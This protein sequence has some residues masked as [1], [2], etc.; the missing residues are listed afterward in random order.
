M[1]LVLVCFPHLSSLVSELLMVSMVLTIFWRLFWR[2]FDKLFKDLFDDLTHFLATFFDQFLTKFCWSF[3][4]R[5]FKKFMKSKLPNLTKLD[6][7]LDYVLQKKSHRMTYR[8]FFWL[9]RGTLTVQRNLWLPIYY[10]VTK[11]S[12]ILTFK[13]SKWSELSSTEIRGNKQDFVQI[14]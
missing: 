14:N 9:G 6:Q 7:I 4:W 2:I 10:L 13:C 3:F 12:A 1:R 8:N 5:I 11:L